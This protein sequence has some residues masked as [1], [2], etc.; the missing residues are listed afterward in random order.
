[1]LVESAH[2]VVR[3][4]TRCRQIRY[5]WWACWAS[6]VWFLADTESLT[7][8]AENGNT[9]YALCWVNFASTGTGHAWVF[10][11]P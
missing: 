11:R 6:R 7:R 3:V 5:V 2:N 1:M 8:D 4:M 10:G 9:I